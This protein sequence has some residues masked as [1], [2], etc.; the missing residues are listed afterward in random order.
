[1]KLF[2]VEVRFKRKRDGRTGVDTI[3]HAA[4]RE[5]AEAYVLGKYPGGTILGTVEFDDEPKHF[6][7]ADLVE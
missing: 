5:A 6:V 4:S 1:M 3:V 2:K 7:I